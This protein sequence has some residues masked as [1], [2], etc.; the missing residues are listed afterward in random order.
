[1]NGFG[2]LFVVQLSFIITLNINQ[3]TAFL[4]CIAWFTFMWLVI[5]CGFLWG[6]V[7]KGFL[8]LALQS[9]LCM[10]HPPGI[11]WMKGNRERENGRSFYS[12]PSSNF[13]FFCMI[14]VQHR[15]DAKLQRAPLFE[16]FYFVWSYLKNEITL[17]RWLKLGE[18]P[19][20]Y[21]LTYVI[22]RIW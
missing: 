2:V 14:F 21:I 4:G 8:F 19:N 13:A 11:L 1:M 15:N 9:M 10:K 3:A 18:T 20:F 6:E 5:C 17:I 12:S 16:Y 22:P 7:H